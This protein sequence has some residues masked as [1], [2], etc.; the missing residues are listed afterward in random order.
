MPNIEMMTNNEITPDYEVMSSSDFKC[1]PWKNGLGS[2]LEIVRSDDK[3]GLRYRI[4]QASVVQDGLFSDFSGLHRTLILLSG[5]GMLLQHSNR[6]D[7][8]HQYT[9][10]L[11][12]ALDMA[13]FSGG[14]KT[15][16]ILNQGSIDDLNIMVRDTDTS[17]TVTV[18]RAP[19][20]LGVSSE[21]NILLNAF[22]AHTECSICLKHYSMEN[23]QIKLPVN[24]LLVIKPTQ[25]WSLW[26]IVVKDG[27]G[28]LI[29][30][31]K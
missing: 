31:S 3:H 22:Y 26:D 4:S 10:Q 6:H 15:N 9:H 11:D 2:T 17:S 29:A 28:V 5:N 18:V 30:I 12:N 21:A 20:S 14:D 1:M 8:H 25:V 16:A 24:S 19:Q 7:Q 27:D 13:C 23:I